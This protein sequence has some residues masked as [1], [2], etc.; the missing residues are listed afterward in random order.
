MTLQTGHHFRYYF[1][2]V[3][4][5]VPLMQVFLEHTFVIAES[6]VLASFKCL[7][8]HFAEVVLHTQFLQLLLNTTLGTFSIP[9][10][11]LFF[12]PMLPAEN[13]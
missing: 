9:R 11:T 12:Q 1:C 8:L 3:G 10:L 7:I 6:S 13:H 2:T 4:S 5:F